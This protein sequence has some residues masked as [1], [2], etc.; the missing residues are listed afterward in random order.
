MNSTLETYM[1][2]FINDVN[3]NKFVNENEAELSKIFKWFKED[4]VKEGS[5]IDYINRYANLPLNENA[6]VSYKAYNW[7]LNGK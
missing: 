1:R 7:N 3:R 5:L 4:F 6:S 2:K